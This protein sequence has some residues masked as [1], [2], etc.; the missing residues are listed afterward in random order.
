M[1]KSDQILAIY[2]H[3][4]NQYKNELLYIYISKKY[5]HQGIS[6]LIKDNY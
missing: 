1:K 5:F 3:G 2:I 6:S 4:S